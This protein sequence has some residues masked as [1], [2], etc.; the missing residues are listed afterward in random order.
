[1]TELDKTIQKDLVDAQKSKDQEKLE[2]LRMVLAEIKNR[3]ID[4]KKDLKEKEVQEILR[5]EIKKRKDSIKAFKDGGRD[6]LA[7]KEEREIAI[8]EKYLPAQMSEEEV[9]KA[10]SKIIKDNSG[11]DFGPLMGKV[12]KELKDKADGALVKDIV[13]KEIKK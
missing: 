12:M 11:M 1:M 5:K 10:V 2:T 9:Q 8:I 13:S 7:Q 6:E 3:S 4:S